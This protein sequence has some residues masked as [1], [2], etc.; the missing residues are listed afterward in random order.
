MAQNL[1][2]SQHDLIQDMILDNKL[3]AY[4]MA[5]IAE[6][7]ERSIK[8]ICSN[9]RYFGTTKTPFNGRRRPQSITPPMPE[10][11]CEHLEKPEL[12]L[13]EIALFL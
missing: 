3:K 8:A 1:A 7:S 10:A 5:N 11:L 9:V 12:Y 4:E 13:E 6:C 2:P